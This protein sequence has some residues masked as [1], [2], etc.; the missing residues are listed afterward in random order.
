MAWVNNGKFRRKALYVTIG[1]ASVAYNFYASF[2][3]DAVTYPEIFS[4][5]QFSRMSDGDYNTRLAAFYAYLETQLSLTAG[6]L[7]TYVWSEGQA[8]NGTNVNSCPLPSVEG[9]VE[10][11]A[12]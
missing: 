9:S 10:T 8:P 5:T 7:S 12:G 1:G 2:T 4:D 3:Y 11:P 6:D